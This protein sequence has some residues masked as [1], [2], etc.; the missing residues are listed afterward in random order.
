[1]ETKHTPLEVLW[2]E[3]NLPIAKFNE[4]VRNQETDHRAPL[5]PRY[6]SRV[7]RNKKGQ[8][9]SLESMHSLRRGFLNDRMYDAMIDYLVATKYLFKQKVSIVSPAADGKLA[10]LADQLKS[11]H[12]F[13]NETATLREL[14]EIVITNDMLEGW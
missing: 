5:A 2:E 13:D 4:V 10:S 7:E 12:L 3:K 1:M 14:D 9:K 8:T 11:S 6:S